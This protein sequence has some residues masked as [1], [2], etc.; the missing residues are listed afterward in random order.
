MIWRCIRISLVRFLFPAKL[1]PFEVHQAHVLRFHE[2]LRHQSGRAQ[3]YVFADT[4]RD[5]SSV[6]IDVSSMPKAFADFANLRLQLLHFRRPEECI[7]I[8]FGTLGTDLCW[9]S[10]RR[11][12]R[13][14]ISPVDAVA[15]KVAQEVTR[16]GRQQC[17]SRHGANIAPVAQHLFKVTNTDNLFHGYGE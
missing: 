7:Q 16:R 17:V 9:S 8:R 1:V 12:R 14:M 6:A 15:F 4:H 3:R 11:S 13:L 10:L 5:V 2:P